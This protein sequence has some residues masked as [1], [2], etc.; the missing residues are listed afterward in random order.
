M[1]WRIVVLAMF[2][3]LWTF[4]GASQEEG[5]EVAR[6][7]IESDE[8][9]GNIK[10][11]VVIRLDRTLS[12]DQLWKLA[13]TIRGRNLRVERTFIEYYLPDMVVGAGAWATTHFDPTLEIRIIGFTAETQLQE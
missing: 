2:L 5:F 13:H 12:E 3:G 10:R 7:R 11:S 4:P 8:S 1:L 6:P 9:L